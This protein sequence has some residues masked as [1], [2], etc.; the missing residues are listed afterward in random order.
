M[1][2]TRIVVD[3]LTPITTELVESDD[4]LTRVIVRIGPHL[5]LDLVEDVADELADALIE[6]ASS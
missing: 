1:T 2:Q 4:D 5:V 3:T 6:A